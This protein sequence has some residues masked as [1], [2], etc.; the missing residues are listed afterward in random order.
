LRA[1]RSPGLGWF[2]DWWTTNQAFDDSGNDFAARLTAV[3][4][5][6]D[7]GANYLH[8]AVSGRYTGA[9]AGSLRLR[10]R[11]ESNVTAYDVD[12]DQ[13]AGDHAN[14]LGL[15]SAWGRGPLFVTTDYARAWLDAPASENPEFWG[16]YIVASYVLTGEDRPYDKK[17]AYARRILPERKGGAWELVGRYSH[18][19]ITDRVVN[20][21][22]SIAGTIGVNWGRRD[23][24]R[25][26][27]TTA[28]SHWTALAAPA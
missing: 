23:G 22:R 18:V 1:I 27:L 16:A 15:E 21:G 3:P 17:V 24:G 7:G 9:D 12:T 5:W 26:A 25:S 13:L 11:P 28:T 4:Y 20:G 10:G 6:S 8:L 2:N 14:A 19:D